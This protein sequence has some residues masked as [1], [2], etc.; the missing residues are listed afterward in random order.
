MWQFACD[1]IISLWYTTYLGLSVCINALGISTITTSFYPWASMTAFNITDSNTTVVLD[2]SSLLIQSH[3]MLPFA[4][5]RTLIIPPRF[6]VI[7]MS[8]YV[9]RLRSWIVILFTSIG[10]KHALSCGWL[11]SNNASYNIFLPNLFIPFYGL[12]VW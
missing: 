9:A 3:W 5:A 2:T 12:Y 8:N 1:F 11:I 4:Q 7:N 6:S 10:L